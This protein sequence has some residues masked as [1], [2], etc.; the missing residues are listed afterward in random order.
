MTWQ[1]INIL[2]LTVD[3][4]FCYV[5]SIWNDAVYMSKHA[6]LTFAWNVFACDYVCFSL[7]RLWRYDSSPSLQKSPLVFTAILSSRPINWFLKIILD[8]FWYCNFSFFLQLPLTCYWSTCTLNIFHSKNR[9][10]F[11]D[12]N[13]MIKYCSE[14]FFAILGLDEKIF[15]QDWKAIQRQCG[16]TLKKL[17]TSESF[18][19]LYPFSV[20]LGI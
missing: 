11:W 18:L 17:N 15:V 1:L 8:S 19:F 13:I 4:A 3:S 5:Y 12:L 2:C 6:A 7:Q 20:T 10:R 14:F 16:I 9:W